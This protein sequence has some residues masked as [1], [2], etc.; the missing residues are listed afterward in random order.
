MGLRINTNVTSLVAQHRLVGASAKLNTALERLSSGLRINRG[1]D[2]VVGLLKSESLRSQIRGITTASANIT[3]ARNLLGVAEGALAQLT[4]LAQRLRERTVQGSDDTISANDRANITTAMNDLLNEYSR[5]ATA[6]EFDGVRLI[7]G[8]FANKTFQVGPRSGDTIAFSID[9]ARSDTVGQIA[10]LSATTKTDVATGSN[11][12]D[13]SAATNLV[14]NGVTINGNLFTSDGVSNADSDESA[15]AYVSAINAMAGASG[16]QASIVANVITVAMAAAGDLSSTAQLVINGVTLAATTVDSSDDDSVAAFVT[17]INAQSTRT[18][19]IATYNSSSNDM[20]YTA[21]DGRNIDFFLTAS[22]SHAATVLGLGIGSITNAAS[23]FRGTF[24][25]FADDAWSYTSATNAVIDGN[26]TGSVSVSTNTTLSNIDVSN[27]ANASTS[28]FIL[29]NVIRQLQSRRTEVGSKTIR[30]EIAQSELDIRKE[31]L[32][33]SESK[34][35]DADVA[36]E[37]ANLTSAQI[38]QQAG[39]Q[40]LSRAN[41][42]P[43]IALTLLQA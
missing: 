17:L 30:M 5:I 42:I 11:E 7:D 9:D 13:L 37:T 27:A 25:L 12:L 14:L 2:D 28:V 39:V 20:V 41:A 16:V 38:L 43:Q 24:R 31:N 3:N 23:V 15:I 8:S 35:R 22:V 1:A 6:T 26:T 29:D 40:V 34:I 33:D 18:G 4:D 36:E 21:T 10:L 32:S 19:V